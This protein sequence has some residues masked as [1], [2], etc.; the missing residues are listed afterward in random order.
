[1]LPSGALSDDATRIPVRQFLAKIA[2]PQ[3]KLFQQNELAPFRKTH[4]DGC[5]ASVPSSGIAKIKF[6]EAEA[7]CLIG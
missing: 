5:Y 3:P 1:M 2:T 7:I 4:H 6:E